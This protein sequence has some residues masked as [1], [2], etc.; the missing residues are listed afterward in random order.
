MPELDQAQTPEPCSCDDAK[1]WKARALEAERK[2]SWA[3]ERV[4][5]FAR[6]L[7]EVI[8][9]LPDQENLSPSGA[10]PIGSGATDG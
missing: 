9:E 10:V 8:G 2:L 6:R 7:D 3:Q 4:A 1:A 5:Y